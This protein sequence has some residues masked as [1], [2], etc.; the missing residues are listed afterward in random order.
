MIQIT[1]SV[2]SSVAVSQLNFELEYVRP[3]LASQ[4]QVSTLM[5]KGMGSFGATFTTST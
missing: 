1:I 3:S 5:T 2:D 4:L